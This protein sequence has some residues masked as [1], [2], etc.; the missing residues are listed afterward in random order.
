MYEIN[1]SDPINH[2][3]ANP[4]AFPDPET[5]ITNES[6]PHQKYEQYTQNAGPGPSRWPS[7]IL[8]Q[9]P[10]NEQLS[11][12]TPQNGHPEDEHAD[13]TVQNP[14]G[15]SEILINRSSFQPTTIRLPYSINITERALDLSNSSPPNSQPLLSNTEP[16]I[17]QSSSSPTLNC[18]PPIFNNI[19]PTHH[20]SN[21]T[22]PVNRSLFLLNNT[23]PTLNLP[24]QS[25]SVRRSS[26]LTNNIDS[27]LYTSSSRLS[28]LTTYE[29]S[30]PTCK[31]VH[32]WL[33]PNL[34]QALMG[35][36]CN[37]DIHT[38]LNDL[39]DRLDNFT[40]EPNWLIPYFLHIYINVNL[41]RLF[42]PLKSI[43][44]NSSKLSC[45]GL[46]E[47]QYYTSRFSGKIPYDKNYMPGRTLQKV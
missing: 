17:V 29:P 46:K 44:P 37:P 7:T 45:P 19:G 5:S 35:A 3:S 16:L 30:C 47:V 38:L 39:N 2:L 43:P 27:L 6:Q 13:N 36:N 28:H 9:I 22:G 34:K 31:L 42:Q 11:F 33:N 24:S 32:N 4:E 8:Q 10:E 18:S 40:H 20:T 23:V 26:C 21:L 1:K 12:N 14:V 15:E 41:T 25:P